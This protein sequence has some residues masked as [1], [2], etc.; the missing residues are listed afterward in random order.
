MFIYQYVIYTHA[1]M[2]LTC[3]K[4]RL[5]EGLEVHTVVGEQGFV[6]TNRIRQLLGIGVPEL[7]GFLGRDNDK[8]ACTHQLCN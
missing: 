4:I 8:P 1:T 2:G 6:L 5:S 7:P 3:H